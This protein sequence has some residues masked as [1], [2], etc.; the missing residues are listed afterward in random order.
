MPEV[1]VDTRILT[2]GR[3]LR[4]NSPA[5]AFIENLSMPS[6]IPSRTRAWL[7]LSRGSNLPTVWSNCLAGW[8]LGGGW[9]DG[10]RAAGRLAA[11]LL[12]ASLLYTAGMWLNDAYDSDWDARYRPERPIPAGAVPRQTVVRAGWA[13]IALAWVCLLPLGLAAAAWTLGLTACIE[14]YNRVHKRQ[15]H[16]SWL[17]AGCRFF[18][19]PLA[20]SVSAGGTVPL[21][22][23]GGA[24]LAVYVAG[25]TY[26]ARGESLPGE[27]PPRWPWLL[28]LTPLLGW[29]DVARSAAAYDPRVSWLLLWPFGSRLWQAW[30][31]AARVAFDGSRGR[32]PIGELLAAIPLVDL[33]LSPSLDVLRLAAFVCLFV[34]ARLFQR[35]IPAT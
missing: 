32:P 15:A 18:L 23:V 26:L 1:Q 35:I 2:S 11:L 31:Q 3:N 33:L 24:V 30:R 21:A 5:S 19:Y 34:A 27:T 9:V 6:G 22:L 14:T 13:A 17:M 8:W 12:G 20:A 7:V 29:A 28:L 10:P 4:A 25:I 16:A